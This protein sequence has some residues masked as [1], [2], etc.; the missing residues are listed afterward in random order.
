MAQCVCLYKEG[1]WPAQMLD[2]P[3]QK[4]YFLIISFLGCGGIAWLYGI[5]NLHE[6]KSYEYGNHGLETPYSIAR[7]PSGEG[8]PQT[9]QIMKSVETVLAMTKNGSLKTNGSFLSFFSIFFFLVI[10]I[11]SSDQIHFLKEIYLLLIMYHECSFFIVISQNKVE[12]PPPNKTP[13]PGRIEQKSKIYDL[14]WTVWSAADGEYF[15]WNIF[16]IPNFGHKNDEIAD[17]LSLWNPLGDSKIMWNLHSGQYTH[18]YFR[19]PKN[20][21]F[22]GPFGSRK[23]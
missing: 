5:R 22:W 15:S 3:V 21:D 2:F 9:F 4:I 12:P 13:T 1:C 20:D 8:Q 11:I 18:L 19:E 16:E 10:T 23:K 17:I 14:P 6:N 7:L